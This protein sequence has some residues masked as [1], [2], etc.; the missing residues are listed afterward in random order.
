[1][2]GE[3]F[4]AGTPRDIKYGSSPHARGTH[5]S[6]SSMVRLVRFIPACAG[7]ASL[8]LFLRV[9]CPVHPRMRGERVISL[10]YDG[11][12]GGSS[13]HARGTP[14]CTDIQVSPRRFIPACAGN[15]GRLRR[16]SRW[17]TVHPRMRGERTARAWPA[18]CRNGSSPHARGT[19]TNGVGLAGHPRFIPACAGN[20]LST[21]CFPNPTSVHPRMRGERTGSRKARLTHGGSSPHARGTPTYTYSYLYL[22]RFI[23][24]CAGNACFS[25]LAALN[26]TVHPRMRGERVVLRD[27]LSLLDG[28]SPHARGTREP[29][30]GGDHPNRFIPAC[31]G[32]AHLANFRCRIDTVHP[33]MRGERTVVS[34]STRAAVGSSPHARGTQRHRRL[35]GLWRRFIPACAGNAVWLNAA[36]TRPTVHP[37]MRGERRAERG[38]TGSLGGSSPHARG[39]LSLYALRHSSIRFIPACAGNA[40]FVDH[41]SIL[42]TVHPRMRGER[43]RQAGVTP[44]R[45]RFIPACAGNASSSSVPLDAISVHP[46]MRGERR[47]YSAM[48][49]TMN[50]SSPHARGTRA[51]GHQ[52]ADRGR[53]IPACAGNAQDPGHGS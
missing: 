8:L 21:P 12:K 32:N 40:L 9:Y 45:G 49:S 20:A 6:G 51:T 19:R 5:G 23:P 18:R 36:P 46:R 39:T 50:G 16:C 24:A 22:L 42:N 11:F 44:S 37:R 26:V 1:M 7:T 38:R 53:F 31:A 35:L 14:F 4:P 47:S 30:P 27:G 3:R 34:R 48:M 29:V 52:H 43:G 2:R 17:M 25:R 10:R 33:R 28:S 41:D 15:A 13:P